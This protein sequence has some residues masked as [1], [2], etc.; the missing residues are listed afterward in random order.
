MLVTSKVLEKIRD[1]LIYESRSEFSFQLRCEIY[2]S[3]QNL[4]TDN[5]MHPSFLSL[6]L[7][8]GL[9]EMYNFKSSD[10]ELKSKLIY[11][12]EFLRARMR[13]IERSQSESKEKKELEE[14][15]KNACGRVL[16]LKNKLT[17][18][19]SLDEMKSLFSS[20][21][22]NVVSLDLSENYFLGSWESK[23]LLSLLKSIPPHVKEINLNCNFLFTHRDSGDGDILL[24]GFHALKGKP[25][26]SCEMKNGENSFTRAAIA[27]ISLIRSKSSILPIDS[28]YYILSFLLPPLQKLKRVEY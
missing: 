22:V 8:K 24:K 23:N 21:P 17:S 13:R 10:P 3:I 4:Q 20:L 25:L 19:L 12:I 6:S 28:I 9:S 14:K 11:E 27:F 7:L 5:T 15:I 26:I 16:D 18:Y 1:K 2:I